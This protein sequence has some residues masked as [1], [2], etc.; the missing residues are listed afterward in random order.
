[1]YFFKI[2]FIHKRHTERQ[3]HRQREEKQ[4]PCKESDVGLIPGTPGSL[5]EPKADSKPLSHLSVP[6]MYFLEYTETGGSYARSLW[7]C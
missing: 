4:A 3:R 7:L 5:P 2:V 6:P 1:M